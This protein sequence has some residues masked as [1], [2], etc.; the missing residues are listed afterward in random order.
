VALEI[1]KIVLANF[2]VISLENQP[3][4]RVDANAHLSCVADTKP[5]ANRKLY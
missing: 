3:N 2:A 5:V 4:H 1:G